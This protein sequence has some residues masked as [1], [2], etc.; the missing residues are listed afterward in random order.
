MELDLIKSAIKIAK[1][2]QSEAPS[3][4]NDYSNPKK[5]WNLPYPYPSTPPSSR[6]SIDI[7]G[8]FD[9]MGR[10]QFSDVCNKVLSLSKRTYDRMF[11]YGTIGFGK[12][13]I[14]AAL[15]CYLLRNGKRVVYLPDCRMM[16]HNFMEYVQRSLYLSFGDILGEKIVNCSNIVELTRLLKSLGQIEIY[17]I[18]DQL[19][20][21]DYSVEKRDASIRHIKEK[22]LT[23]LNALTS[24]YYDIRGSSGNYLASANAE[25][26]HMDE[27][28]IGLN[29]GFTKVNN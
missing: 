12:S 3:S 18:I 6:F 20:G 17:F 15:V 14:L 21:L 16:C 2:I 24:A 27:E 8:N 10:E 28:R 26:R 25:L 1:K 7:N 19:N 29:G 23:N 11:V 4:I 5:I 9:Y 13:H 22:A